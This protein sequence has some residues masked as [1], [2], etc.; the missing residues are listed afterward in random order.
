MTSEFSIAV[1]EQ[2]QE[3]RSAMLSSLK[4]FSESITLAGSVEHLAQE[5]KTQKGAP[6]VVF[7]GVDEMERGIKDIKALT[8]Q[9][10]RAS[11][12]ACASEK[13]VEWFLA[14]MR[15]GAVEYLL[16]PIA[17][18]ELIQSLQKVSRLL[19]AGTPEEHPHGEIIAV[20]NPI[21]G[22]GTTT[23]AVN[24]A[25]ALSED[26]TKVALVDLNL[27]AGDV[28]TFLNVNPAYTLSSVTTNVDRLD[29]NFLMSVMTRHAS[30]PFILTEPADV[31]EAVSITA[32]QVQR[33]M[34]ML[35]GIFRYVV[36]DC[37]GQLSGCNMAI[38][39]N[40][41]LI[42]FTTTL[43]LPGLKN[44]KRY[45]S[46]LERKGLGGERVKLVINRYLPRS[47]IQLK[48]AEKVLGL[49]VFQAIPNGYADVVD[50]INKGMPVVKL[51]PKSPVSKAIQGLVERV[52]R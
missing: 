21:G 1:I 48:D 38:F 24:L 43:S 22:M 13:N 18:E 27:D 46:A 19:C 7:L 23:I 28:N 51:Q 4:S 5:R 33:V 45:L 31:D 3:S 49:P 47:D 32:D 30:G 10:P 52:K 40:A 34:E 16:R 39:Q 15:A 37:V 14:L 17:H 2:D 12:I 20:Y 41:S 36:V 26:E 35:R 42:L 25:A 8:A 50:S 9:Y 11:V 44:T 29:A 6:Q